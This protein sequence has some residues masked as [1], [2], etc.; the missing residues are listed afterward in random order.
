MS[1]EFNIHNDVNQLMKLLE[2]EDNAID[3]VSAET[4]ADNLSKSVDQRSKTRGAKDTFLRSLEIKYMLKLQNK[5]SSSRSSRR[6]ATDQTDAIPPSIPRHASTSSADRHSFHSTAT[7]RLSGSELKSPLK[8]P[9]LSTKTKELSTKKKDKRKSSDWKFLTFDYQFNDWSQ[10]ESIRPLNSLSVAEQ[11]SALIED[12]LFVLIGVEG[13]YIRLQPLKDKPNK[14]DIIVDKSGDELL[15]TLAAR[16]TA[17]CPYFSQII[18]FIDTIDNGLVNQSLVAAMRAQI[19]DFFTLISQLETQHRKSD[20][21][22][23]KMWYYLQPSFTHLAILKDIASKVSKSKSI[24]G[25]VLSILHEN[26]ISLTGNTKAQEFCLSLTRKA[27]E[28]YFEIL[29]TWIYEGIIDDPFK[30]FL[31]EDKANE[32]DEVILDDL[33][34]ENRYEVIRSRI[35]V[36]FERH[37]DMIMKTGK[38]LSVIRNCGRQISRP[39]TPEPLIYTTEE[40]VYIENIESAYKFASKELLHL[41]VDE[42]DLIGRLKSIKHYFFMDLGDFIVQFM[43]LAGDELEKDIDDIALNRLDSLLELSLRTSLMNSDAYKDDV[44]IELLPDSLHSQMSQ[45]LNIGVNSIKDPKELSI[46]EPYVLKG[47][48]ALALDFHV[49]WPLSLIISRKNITCYQMLFRHLF[50]CKY[51]ERQLEE[52]WKGNK[53][54]KR[55]TLNAVTGYGQAFA[56]RQ[57]MLNFVQNLEYYIMLEVI[58]PTFHQFLEYVQ[59]KVSSVD[60]MMRSHEDYIQKCLRDAMLTSGELLRAIVQLLRLCIVFSNFMKDSHSHSA[61]YELLDSTQVFECH[62]KDISVSIK[63]T[64]EL[65]ISFEDNIHSMQTDFDSLLHELLE[66]IKLQTQESYTMIPVLNRLDF[67]GFYQSMESSND[68]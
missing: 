6:P 45:I 8:S 44:R 23:Q 31:V 7:Q 24:G 9:E 62:N 27:S 36:F 66:A 57:K 39:H 38:Y 1:S 20:L 50:Y 14:H 47:S 32:S 63:E 56:L 43:D 29:E 59:T 28:S 61:Q 51:V 53:I 4:I 30:E 16:I 13:K 33:F 65:E 68:Y 19:K 42:S 15:Y 46:P 3:G 58:E 2:I 26:T 11:E 54:A 37:S 67:N 35:P 64:K 55:F 52:V 34:W 60:D 5:M 49:S 48:E 21:T 25:A 10:E 40:R 17:L 12:L 22:L 41:L 18:H